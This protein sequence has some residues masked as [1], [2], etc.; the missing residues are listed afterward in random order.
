MSETVLSVSQMQSLI[1]VSEVAA[2]HGVTKG[3]VRRAAKAGTIPGAFFV[4]KHYGFDP[5]L[6]A[7]WEPETTTTGPRRADGRQVYHVL[8]TLV[9]AAAAKEA[10]TEFIDPRAKA[11]ARRDAKAAQG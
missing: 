7:D 2:M 3:S 6:V 9:E 4:L 1:S 5:K 10:G 11:K 8:W